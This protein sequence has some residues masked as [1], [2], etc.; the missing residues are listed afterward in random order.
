[1]LGGQ[2]HRLRFPDLSDSISPLLED[3]VWWVRLQAVRSLHAIECPGSIDALERLLFDE[4]WQVRNEA[5]RALLALGECS[6]DA[7][8][9]VLSGP[10]RYAKDSICEEIESTNYHVRLMEL[11]AGE[12][13][14]LREKARRILELMYK[15]GFSTPHGEYLVDGAND[16]VKSELWT[17]LKQPAGAL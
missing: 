6:L 15:L 12:D 17:I 13:G 9:K 14:A 1:V 11:L 2:E 8:L 5:A 16:A 10:D 7:L 4:K 3:P